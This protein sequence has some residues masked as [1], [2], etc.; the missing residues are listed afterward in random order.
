MKQISGLL[1]TYLSFTYILIILRS[2]LRCYLVCRLA[3]EKSNFK[4]ET[5]ASLW[6]DHTMMTVRMSSE[7]RVT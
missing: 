3:T 6:Q 1:A 7:K 4:D 5:P 2:F